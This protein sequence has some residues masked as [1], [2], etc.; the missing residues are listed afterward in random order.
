M[1][2]YDEYGDIKPQ[3]QRLSFHDKHRIH[4][5][6]DIFDGDCSLCEQATAKGY[7]SYWSDDD[8]I[9]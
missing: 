5:T 2:E 8:Y 9:Q 3:V 6:K 1:E 7:K 4:M